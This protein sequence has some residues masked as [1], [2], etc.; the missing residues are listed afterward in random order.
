MDLL[1]TGIFE[2]I[3]ADGIFADG[4]A[5]YLLYVGL[6]LFVMASSY[7][8]GSLSSAIIVSKDMFKDDVRNHGS[9]NAGLTNVLRTYGMGAAGLTLLGDLL[10]A[11]LSVLICA[12]IFGFEYNGGISLNGYCYLAGMCAVLGH[13]YPVFYGFKGGKGVL[14]TAAMALILAPAVC[15]ALLLTFIII[16]IISGFVSLGSIIVAALFPIAISLYSL[17]VGGGLELLTLIVTLFLGI[18][19]IWC[20][21]SNIK[22][23][24]SGSEKRISVGKKEKTDE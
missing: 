1:N 8:L 12:V 6:I 5:H 21:R 20:H 14:V 15:A 2:I 9:G 17:L 22:R 7:L 23:L 24:L 11:A 10:K 13:V 3:C 19:V 16:V 4:W 18:F